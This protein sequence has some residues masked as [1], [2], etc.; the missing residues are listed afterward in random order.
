MSRE[1][2]VTVLMMPQHSIIGIQKWEEHQQL[3]RVKAGEWEKGRGTE[4][5]QKNGYTTPRLNS[6]LLPCLGFKVGIV[7][8]AWNDVHLRLAAVHLCFQ[9]PLLV[10]DPTTVEA[11]L[12]VQFPDSCIDVTLSLLEL[13]FRESPSGGRWVTLN[14]K[15]LHIEEKICVDINLCD[16]SN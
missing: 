5:E 13:A 11:G 16:P 12:L 14:K 4:H 7:G 8:D 10:D 1:I 6:Y 3:T 9:E 15:T 2:W